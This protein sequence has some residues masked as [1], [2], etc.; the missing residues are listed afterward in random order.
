[1]A[2]LASA[3]ALAIDLNHEGAFWVGDGGGEGESELG[4]NSIDGDDVAAA[5]LFGLGFEFA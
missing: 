5:A 3:L 4:S 1:M 2:R